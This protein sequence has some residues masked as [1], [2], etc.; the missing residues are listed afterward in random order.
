VDITVTIFYQKLV[1]DVVASANLVGNVPSHVVAATAALAL[2]FNTVLMSLIL[3]TLGEKRAMVIV[4]YI[5]YAVIAGFLGTIGWEIFSGSF[6]VLV[7]EPVTLPSGLVDLIL[8]QPLQLACAVAM[9]GCGTVLRK[10]GALP[11]IVAFAP[12]AL[13]LFGFWLVVLVLNVPMEELHRSQ[14]LFPAEGLLP[15]WNVWAGQDLSAVNWSLIS[16]RVSTFFGLGFILVLSL[17]LRIAGIEGSVPVPVDIDEEVKWTGITNIMTGLCGGVIGSH[18]PGLTVFN[19]EAGSSDAYAS[20]LTAV[21]QLVLWLSGLP[22]ANMLPRFL[23]AGIL[24]NLGKAMLFEWMW[25]ARAKIGTAELSIVYIQVI[26][27]VLYGLLPSVLIGIICACIS[28]QGRLMSLNVLKYHLSGKSIQSYV[29]RGAEEVIALR[30][31]ID[32]I[33]MIGLDGYI[34]EGPMFKLSNYLKKYIESNSRIRYLIL[35]FRSCQTVS[36][37]ACAQLSKLHNFLLHDKKITVMY[38]NTDPCTAKRLASFG[39]MHALQEFSSLQHALEHCENSILEHKTSN[40]KNRQSEAPDKATKI[41]LLA[42]LLGCSEAQASIV[43]ELGT[44]STMQEGQ[45]LKQSNQGC[46]S[47]ELHVALPRYSEVS[48]L[49]DLGSARGSSHKVLQSTRGVVCGLEGVLF[50]ERSRQTSVVTRAGSLVLSVPGDALRD[51]LRQDASLEACLMRVAAKQFLRRSDS[52]SQAVE[53][54]KG[55]GWNG[56]FFDAT[57]ASV[58]EALLDDNKRM[59]RLASPTI[60]RRQFRPS[61]DTPRKNRRLHSIENLKLQW[62]DSRRLVS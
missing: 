44:W 2:P 29:H 34:A 50:G 27:A 1:N 20:I 16:P 60:Q 42:E 52:L 43:E 32:S 25:S 56:A 30:Q 51:L 12:M 19:F 33:E 61:A 59:S 41:G 3:Y 28:S 4:P 24:M 53:L 62:W 58:S 14:W 31:Q 9:V 54:N 13:S 46:L 40:G 49:I 36:V 57:T 15:F 10:L 5:P 39:V 17:A 7:G 11:R 38:T 8:A 26:S 37:S 22:A 6:A 35:D 45:N 48:E 55:G 23:L 18:S 21:L 47:R